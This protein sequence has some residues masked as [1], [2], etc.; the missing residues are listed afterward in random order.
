MID[1]DHFKEINDTFGHL[2]GDDV[3]REIARRVRNCLRV[4]DV[5]ARYGGE[6]FAILMAQT[7]QNEAC[8]VAERI[9]NAV[10][11]TPFDVQSNQPIPITISLGVTT[12]TAAHQNLNA[13][14]KSADDALYHAKFAGRNRLSIWQNKL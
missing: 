13:L 5:A 7:G 14:V 2:I 8:Q 6:E 10:A 4:V 9:R 3:L 1:V 12:L 11:E